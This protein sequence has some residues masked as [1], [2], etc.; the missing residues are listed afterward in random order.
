MT[1]SIYKT[2]QKP[3]LAEPKMPLSAEMLA[4]LDPLAT[5]EFPIRFLLDR[6]SGALKL[7]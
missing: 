7:S 5:Y 4:L 3:T 1:Y 6:T 2:D